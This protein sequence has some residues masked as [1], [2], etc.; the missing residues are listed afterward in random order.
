MVRRSKSVYRL[1]YDDS[2]L[3]SHYGWKWESQL[4]QLEE[5]YEALRNG[6]G[7]TT[8]GPV[9]AED[10]R[11]IISDLDDRGRWVSTYGG[12]RLVGQAKMPLGAKYLS[13]GLFSGN[14]EILSEYIASSPKQ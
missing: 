5:D 12:E 8:T 10:V 13:S 4:G 1:T 14:V 9:K 2:N 7:R 11:R 6:D 3:P